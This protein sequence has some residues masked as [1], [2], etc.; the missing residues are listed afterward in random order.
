[1]RDVWLLL[2]PALR[3]VFLKLRPAYW[4]I[5]VVVIL[6]VRISSI[7]VVFVGIHIL[8]VLQEVLL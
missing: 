2:L 7:L 1:V 8:V 4:L 5:Y 3:E 6:L